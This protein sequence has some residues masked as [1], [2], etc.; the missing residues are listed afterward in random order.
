M[1]ATRI[2]SPQFRGSWAE[3]SLDL[4][5]TSL[6]ESN[7]VLINLT[8]SG[9]RHSPS[10]SSLRFVSHIFKLKSNFNLPM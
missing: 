4:H 1:S 10:I 8:C 7:S 6:A 5:G 2:L 3:A 9:K